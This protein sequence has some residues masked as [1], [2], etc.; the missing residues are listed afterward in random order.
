MNKINIKEALIGF[1]PLIATV[2]VMLTFS[3]IL[4]L[5]EMLEK[6]SR[7]YKEKYNQ[8]EQ[9]ADTNQDGTLSIEERLSM[10]SKMGIPI[11][12]P[13]ETRMPSMSELEIYIQNMGVNKK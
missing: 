6:N 8:V 3:G 7:V 9:I 2:S 10:Y 13:G 1:S 11:N 12:V 5:N 4:K